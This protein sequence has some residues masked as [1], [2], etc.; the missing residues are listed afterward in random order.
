MNEGDFESPP[1]IPAPLP[2]PRS[3][4]KELTYIETCN[5]ID[6]V[7]SSFNRWKYERGY[8]SKDEI[9]NSR[10]NSFIVFQSFYVELFYEYN[11]LTETSKVS[12]ALT[13]SV[14]KDMNLQSRWEE[15]KL[16]WLWFN[17]KLDSYCKTPP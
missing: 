9:T 10:I 8:I 15:M 13:P 4:H 1:P 6:K 7:D 5:F 16:N 11:D 3:I 2:S 17:L 12:L 14:N